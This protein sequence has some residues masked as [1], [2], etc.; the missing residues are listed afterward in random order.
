MQKSRRWLV[1][2]AVLWPVPVGFVAGLVAVSPAAQ[3]Q[4]VPTADGAGTTVAQDGDQYDISGGTQAGGNLFHEFDEFSLTETE[5]ANFLG[6]S[7]VFNIVGQVS[8]GNPS[9][10]D[11]Q[12]QVSGTDADLYLVNP[13]GVFFGPD[14]QLN[15]P[16][17]LTVTTADQVEFDGAVL[18]VLE[19]GAD[20]AAFLGEP[21]ALHFTETSASAVVNQGDLAVA[22]GESLSLTGGN[23]VNTG[24]LSAPGGDIGLVAV[25]GEST[26]RYGIPGNVLSLELTEGAVP[27]GAGFAVTDLPALLTGSSSP[28]VN[29]L[30]L[31]SDGSYELGSLQ[32]GAEEVSVAGEI[33][34][35]ATVG[36]GGAIALLGRSV[37]AFDAVI[38]AS[39]GNGGNIR[40]GRDVGSGV[41]PT[42][43]LVWLHDTSVVRADGLAGAGGDIA[44][45]STRRARVQGDISA[46]GTTLGGL[47]ETSSPR[48]DSVNLRVDASGQAENGRWLVAPGD[49]DIV[50]GVTGFNQIDPSLIEATL[51]SGTDIEITTTDGTGDILL[52]DSIAQNGSSNANLTLTGRRFINNGSTIDLSSTG[53]LTFEINQVNAESNPDSGSIENAIAAIGNVSGNRRISLGAGTYDFANTLNI[54]TAVEIEGASG[55]TTLLNDAGGNRL[56]AVSSD[57]DVGFAN[58]TFSGSDTA[59][60]G[61]GISNVGGMLRI[62]NST[63]VDNV[64]ST[65]GA[66]SNNRGGSL[67]VSATQFTGNQAEGSGGAV[68]VGNDSVGVFHDVSFRGNSAGDDAGALFV[69]GSKVSV[70]DSVFVSNRSAD[71]GGALGVQDSDDVTFDGVSFDNNVS[72]SSG[73][74]IT[75][76]AG[77]TLTLRDTTLEGNTAISS[78]GA[79]FS[80]DG[81]NLLLSGSQVNNNQVFAGRGG[82]LH[83][84]NSVVTLNSGSV[85]NGNIA[86]ANGGALSS[87]NSL[88]FVED[89]SFSNNTAGADGGGISFV[90]GSTA[91]LR[92][93]VFENNSASDDGGGLS[94]AQNSEVTVEDTQFVGN[95]AVN[96]GGLRGADAST[97]M[98]EGGSF[99][100]NSAV[101]GEGGA[102]AIDA[103]KASLQSVDIFDN[104]AATNGGGVAQ[105]A[106]ALVI[107]GS[108]LRRNEANGN[109]G[110]I[111]IAEAATTTLEGSTLLIDNE[112]GGHGGGLATK[113]TGTLDIEDA[114]WSGNQAGDSGGG[115][116]QASSGDLTIESMTFQGNA[117][118]VNG[119]ALSLSGEG[120]GA[121]SNVT[122][123]ENTAQR[124][125]GGLY[126]TDDRTITLTSA[127]VA[128]N[129]AGNDGGGL[130][131]S[132][133]S[134]FVASTTNLR[135]NR[136]GNEGG[137]I[138]STTTGGRLVLRAGGVSENVAVDNG[139]G[140]IVQGETAVDI[141]ELLF[142]DN[143]SEMGEG[144]ALLAGNG[145]S[146]NVAN[147]TF[148][149]N[150]SLGHGGAIYNAGDLNLD[151]LVITDN[152][153]Q[154]NGGGLYNTGRASVFDSRFEGN[155]AAANGGGLANEN[156]LR[157]EGLE[158]VA[159]TAQVGGGLSLY[160]SVATIT[161]SVFEANQATTLGGGIAAVLSEL[162][163]RDSVLLDN[164]AMGDGG[165]VRLMGG[166]TTIET[167]E[168]TANQA[169][170]GGGLEVSLDGEVIVRDSAF[171][172]NQASE[173]GGG[174][175]VD[176]VSRLV[177]T[178]VTFEA[179]QASEGG[180]LFNR[181]VSELVNT[182]FSGN[183]AESVGG[184][185]RTTGSE[186]DL[187]LQ[188]TTLTLNQAVTSGGGVSSASDA[189][190]TRLVNS[191][192][193][194]NTS[195]TSADVDGIFLDGGHNLIGQ[196]DGGTGFTSSTLAGTADAPIDPELALL[197]D[198]GG[199][200]RTH[201]P[202]AT[203]VVVN[204]GQAHDTLPAQDQRGGDRLVGQSVDIGSVELA[205][206]QLTSFEEPPIEPSVEPPADPPVEPPVDP[207]INPTTDDET[208]VVPTDLSPP[209][210]LL[211]SPADDR[212]VIHSSSGEQ[213]L[214]ADNVAIRKLE[215]FLGQSFQDYWDLPNKADLSFDEVQAVLRRAQD[216]YAV[217]SAVVY[218]V[219]VSEETR[220][221]N[222]DDLLRLEPEL[223]ADD[224]LNLAVVMPEGDLVSYELPVTRR[225]AER[226]VRML[227]S[228]VADP[229]DNFGHSPLT[230]QLYQWLLAPLEEDLAAQGIQN[231]MYA[232]D[233]GLRTAPVTAMK[234]DDGYALERYGISVVPSMGLMETAFSDPVRRATVAMGV[235][236]FEHEAPLPAVP[237][238]LAVLKDT[239][240][241]SQTILNEGTTAAALDA[242]KALAQPGVLHLA[243]HATFDARSPESSYIQLWDDPLSMKEFSNLGWQA[244][245]LELLILSACSTA[246]SSPNSELGFAGLAAASGVDAS[247]G[248]LWQVSD[249]GT[250]ALM[251]E[252]YA[253]LES[254]DLRYEA[255]RQAQLALLK[256]ETRIEDGN[257]VTSRG[258]VDLPDEWDLPA[259]ATMDHPFFWSAFT[260]VGNPW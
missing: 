100:N 50:S 53:Q 242:V 83:V 136:A 130:F 56:F 41:L 89:T 65:G 68:F 118:G 135:G 186:A 227:R 43:V 82:G 33:S 224:L 36:D 54:N 76:W 203:S 258:E 25:D 120:A 257:L 137:A 117:A 216:E 101:D 182:T 106:G 19:Q 18:N 157:A 189:R 55:A 95:S 85:L 9:Y 24:T 212:G 162:V 141:S 185:I 129:V 191:I 206:D 190:S 172:Q 199:A 31:R 71:D 200:T 138:S 184:A 70:F 90:N 220:E 195:V 160:E 256:G 10:I 110:A 149:T 38:D 255:L 241:V 97:V 179:N 230:Q 23:V 145:T 240:P 80:V 155:Q 231:L 181:S 253:Q 5:T 30:V 251:G 250:L 177:A 47:V 66:I 140:V 67:A 93:A 234:G 51:D 152:T 171:T 232:L 139:G 35:R 81:S 217:N 209:I 111:A 57:G 112:A 254:T 213:T 6:D 239:V 7:N 156:T 107:N 218:A 151:T 123:N 12:V 144:G 219:F 161:D 236:E 238:E 210:W 37:D 17:S 122:I 225:D 75:T 48:L 108:D 148:A 180:G 78:G 245:D 79:I 222:S 116:Y 132:G 84:D 207:T 88:A 109:G 16:G 248:S 165:G 196:I 252:F 192:V 125:G 98:V 214:S 158:V 28:L 103:S 163:V 40:I 61:G 45:G 202:L 39:G 119:G 246:L 142:R 27:N 72:L 49:I 3:A 86:S 91:S 221:D 127:A 60:R 34:T 22:P 205:A 69:K 59:G 166:T 2:A 96:G 21:S 153:T 178:G 4:V 159:N 114:F 77:S 244:S 229:E 170:F 87:Q 128:D 14:A 46:Q 92:N 204:A 11:G 169:R 249:V 174:I 8:G 154:V 194:A 215:R 1:R 26:V 259:E 197:A 201:Q 243:T 188:N 167:T 131:Q 73:G 233:Q 15:L 104:T 29:E 150:Q 173:F 187:S 223:A 42:S 52:S 198:N 175:Q 126:L 176:D 183:V 20:Y 235:S 44:V 121:I 58:L 228:T 208:M 147:T 62:D 99:T 124:D 146:V 168:F 237:I 143:E 63:F 113:G 211:D 32:I 164:Q 134:E 74:A 193:A 115:L 247:V 105:R 94:L 102:I 13:S 64:A 133:S 260:M 226:Q